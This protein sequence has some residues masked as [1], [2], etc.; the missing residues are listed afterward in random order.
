MTKRLLAIILVLS[1]ALALGA[2]GGGGGYGGDLYIDGSEIKPT[3]S[4][5]SLKN[6]LEGDE[7]E[8]PYTENPLLDET[9]S[10]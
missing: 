2:C 10:S 9:P 8:H 5:S 1:P 3:P 7:T 4:L 6:G